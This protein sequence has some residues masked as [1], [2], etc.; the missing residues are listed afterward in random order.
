MPEVD[1]KSTALPPAPNRLRAPIGR[2]LA[3]VL[4]GLFAFIGVL[5]LLLA[6]AV[7]S[8][9]VRHWAAA[10]TEEVLA[11]EQ[12][13]ARFEVA[14]KLWPPGLE[15]SHVVVDA[16]D[17][18]DSF[19][20]ATGIS[21]KPRIFA[22]L[23]GLP[24]I[25]EVEV[26]SP[27][28]RVVLA[29]GKLQ[30]LK[31][32]EAGP[33]PGPFHAPFN[34]VALTDARVDLTI[35]GVH[36]IASDIDVDVSAE[37]DPTRGSTLEFAV[38][39]G[40][41]EV[42]RPRVKDETLAFDDDQICSIDARLH[43][44]PDGLLVRRLSLTG[45]ADLDTGSG[46]TPGC[47]LLSNDKRVVEVA[48]N[49]VRV[50]FPKTKGAPPSVE[51]H[52]HVRLPVGV[53]ERLA[54]LPTTDGWIGADAD[55]RFVAGMNLPDLDGHIEAHDIALDKFHFAEEI[56]G[57]VSVHDDIIKA[58]KLYVGLSGG[59]VNLTNVEL[60]PFA[61]GIQ[62]R[63]SADIHDVDFTK[64]MHDL[65]VAEHPHVAW[66]I[67][68]VHVPLF[69]G[70]IIPLKLDCDF[71]AITPTFAV[72]D[73]AVDDPQKQRIVS[74]HDGRVGA[75]LAVRPESVQFRA[76]HGDLPHTHIEGGYVAIAYNG[77]VQVDVTKA[78]AGLEDV[79]PIATTRMGGRVLVNDFHLMVEPLKPVRLESD[80]SV[81]NYTLD[82]MSFG[83]VTS[84]HA[85]L[86]DTVLELKNVHAKKGGSTYALPAGK[87][88]FGKPGQ[89]PG[90]HVEGTVAADAFGV[91]DLLSI[92]HLDEDPRFLGIDAKA[93]ADAQ[94]NVVV[95]GPGDPCGGGY[96]NVHATTHLTGVDLFGEKFDDG[97]ADFDLRWRDRLAGFP[98][99]EL[100]VHALT[101]H[102]VR[103]EKDG[104]TV[105][106]ILGSMKTDIGGALHGN[107]VLEGVPLSRLQTLGAIGSDLDGSVSGIAQVSGTLDAI[108]MDADVDVSPIDYKGGHY[109]PSQM[110]VGLLQTSPV[111]VSGHTRCGGVIGGQFDKEAYLQDTSSHGAL[112]VA[113]T[114]FGGQLAV[115]KLTVTREK[116]AV[117]SGALSLRK[118]DFAAI[119]KS[120]GLA[121][122]SPPSGEISGEL[123]IDGVKQGAYDEAIVRFAPS[124]LFVERE[125]KRLSLRPTGAWLTLAA[126]TLTVSPLSFDL[127]TPA[128]LTGSISV[129][130]SAT[131][132]THDPQLDFS[133]Q[134]MPLDLGVLVGI[135]PKLESAKGTL[136]GSV[137]AF[138]PAKDP[139]VQGGLRVRSGELSIKG[140]PGVI[141][142]LD[143][144]I[145]ADTS[146]LRISRATA[147]F[148]GGTLS[149][150]G[151]AP[152]KNFSFVGAYADIAVRSVRLTPLDGINVGLDADLTLATAESKSVDAHALPS[153]SGDV[154]ITSAEYTRPIVLA[155]DL[156]SIG[157]K[158][159][160]TV[161]D[162]YDPS[163]DVLSLDVRVHARAPLRIKNNLAD[164]SL[165]TESDTLL[166]SGTNQR[167]GLRGG[168][169]A[170]PGGR[171]R[172]PFGASVFE[173]KQAFLRFDDPTRIA[174]NV[175]VLA[176]TEYRRGDTSSSS[177]GPGSTARGGSLWR[178]G[179]HAYG[180]TDDLKIEMTSDP[181]L[182]QEDIVLL[183]TIGMTRAE[184]DQLQAGALGAGAALEAFSAV[185]G[186]STAVKDAIPVI[187]DFRF[188]SAY[189]SKTGR[190][191]PQVTI[192]KRI[193]SDVRAN[194]SKGLSEDNDLRA[195]IQWRLS[196]RV[197]LQGSYD[198]VSDVTSSSVGNLGM[199]LRWRL[200][201]E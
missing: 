84:L 9:W 113:G 177:S 98:G 153:L 87:I 162:T 135:V 7:R 62:L 14:V 123:V 54:N 55:V 173:V 189:S 102:K 126:D 131:K 25:D 144:D 171:F 28:A 2:G 8:Q 147:K 10:Q 42:H 44:D 94:F 145:V 129:S 31:L 111:Q 134:L 184:L 45:A 82:D 58:P 192:G 133:A 74:F 103:R 100:D 81:T 178:I 41:V 115:R 92:F 167:F 198:N 112:T 183:L 53:A 121:S 71:D 33:S 161:V 132:V 75:H 136:D 128:G 176:E 195:N 141:G 90:M 50:D 139:N 49:H 86:T 91:R 1:R 68:E 5:P 73:R 199:D 125:G 197:S 157:G 96:V 116:Q 3:R 137:H 85:S 99:A 181:P 36:A 46:T 70:T 35:D 29:N 38:R 152:M 15:L 104:S 120:L 52:A 26:A 182:S 69:A 88:D 191:G 66:E 30:N 106:S 80:G 77:A 151:R 27:R 146:E 172:L 169:K 108:Q 149:I 190:T 83:D 170:L 11:Q 163:L 164:I 175:D 114:A 105:G 72:Y 148:S 122:E 118:L 119:T 76:A 23:A 4:C 158:S 60:K 193:T 142:G 188:G 109:G 117:I 79:A 174:P 124:G 166:V 165:V 159:K 107:F 12:I 180:E 63:A 93:G 186:A 160:R 47:D 185:S 18:G 187:D 13:H 155:S 43:L 89:P 196:N 59:K 32:P 110:H 21:V 101:L 65:G 24:R 150:T 156:T 61:P 17:G 78:D 95:G 67:K 16:T 201:F 143:A 40:S 6:I 140:V 200:E 34:V 127:S 48:L 64:L 51:G 168:L 19:L 20:E 138:G 22:L 57:D 97:D 130:G 39:G 179:L 56:D 154:T 37:D 194:V